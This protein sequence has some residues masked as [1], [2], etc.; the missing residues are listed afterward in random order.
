M[1]HHLSG[2]HEGQGSVDLGLVIPELI[3]AQ[4]DVELTR[5]EEGSALE[6]VSVKVVRGC[7]F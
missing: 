2:L 5:A 3:F 6:A 1:E 7:R 4:G